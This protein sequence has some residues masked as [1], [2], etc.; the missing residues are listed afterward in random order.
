MKRNQIKAIEI[1]FTL[2]PAVNDDFNGSYDD[3]TNF[4]IK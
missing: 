4:E 3:D 2:P 1:Y